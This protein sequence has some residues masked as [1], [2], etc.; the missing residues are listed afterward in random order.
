MRHAGH[1]VPKGGGLRVGAHTLVEVITVIL[2]LSILACVTIPRLNLGAV[3]KAEAEAVALQVM[4]DLRRARS[5]AILHAARNPDGFA[6]VMNGPPG[7]YSSYRIVDLQD[8][9]V[10]ADYDIPL[11][12]H[13][14]GGQR[15]E[16]GPLGN[17]RDGSDDE[18]RVS[19]EGRIRIITV[20]PATG[21]VKCREQ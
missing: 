3:S 9:T 17:L 20:I 8:S 16:F 12:V 15:F 5:H 10:V 11:K 2:V 14:S 19:A 21:M 1:K 7:H 6:V 13:C 18:L 4:T